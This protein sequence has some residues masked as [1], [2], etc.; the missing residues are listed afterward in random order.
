MPR[1]EEERYRQYNRITLPTL[2]GRPGG[3]ARAGFD[4]YGSPFDRAARGIRDAFTPRYNENPMWFRGNTSGQGRVGKPPFMNAQAAGINATPQSGRGEG[5]IPQSNPSGAGMTW[6]PLTQQS[7][8]SGR[9]GMGVG[10]GIGR[11]GTGGSLGVAGAGGR[12]GFGVGG[13]IGSPF[14]NMPGGAGGAGGLSP[15]EAMA[16]DRINKSLGEGWYEN[17]VKTRGMSPVDFY[18]DPRNKYW[19]EPDTPDGAINSAIRDELNNARNAAQWA[20]EHGNTPIPQ[21]AWERWYYANRQ[22]MRVDD[23]MTDGSEVVY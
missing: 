23:V 3:D 1:P 18:R 16:R 6:N 12:G 5:N 7:P 11:A 15:M 8:F 10:G 13:G 19:D 14:G 2:T 9:P 21:E 20:Q 22:G 17:F 4:R